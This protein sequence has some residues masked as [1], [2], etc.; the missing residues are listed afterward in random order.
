MNITNIDKT[1]FSLYERGGM[2]DK[3]IYY[4]QSNDKGLNCLVVWT[5]YDELPKQYRANEEYIRA[6][7]FSG[8]SPLIDKIEADLGKCTNQQETDRCIFR[9]LTPFKR[10]ADMLNDS[11]FVE[12]LNSNS[13][14]DVVCV[15]VNMT[16]AFYTYANRLYA[17]LIQHG[18]DLMQYQQRANIYLKRQW[19]VADIEPYIGSR[20]LAEYYLNQLPQEQPQEQRQH[21]GGSTGQT[22]TQHFHTGKTDD[23][24]LLILE[25][26]TTPDKNGNSY[27]AAD[28]PAAA[29]LYVCKGTPTAELVKPLNWLASQN[30]LALLVC[31]MF[32]SCWETAKACFRINGKE[33]NVKSMA[34]DR[35][36]IRKGMKDEPKK[37][38]RLLNIMNIGNTAGKQ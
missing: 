12:L 17:M 1:F 2:V 8:S 38:K 7:L 31:E 20:E 6:M 14:D 21:T 35:S 5:Y 28:T 10:L 3:C 19:S 9:L 37:H 18:I 22:L 34:N 15:L 36:K 24:L 13:T 33:P 30:E 32:N 29:W 16:R 26:L 23:V 4:V 25:A 11:K 27:L